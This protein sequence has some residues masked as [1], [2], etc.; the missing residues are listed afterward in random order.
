MAEKL[1]AFYTQPDVLALGVTVVIIWGITKILS[2]IHDFVHW[3]IDK[4]IETDVALVSQHIRGYLM[5]YRKRNQCE[6]IHLSDVRAL[7]CQQFMIPTHAAARIPDA[8]W[9]ALTQIVE[10]FFAIG[11]DPKAKAELCSGCL[12]GMVCETNNYEPTDFFI[13][14]EFSLNLSESNDKDPK[15]WVM[16]V[17]R[18]EDDEYPYYIQ[19]REKK[20]LMRSFFEESA[21][22]TYDYRK[23]YANYVECKNKA[24]R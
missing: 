9:R 23:V 5:D 16:W 4:D 1:W 2:P 10:C 7:L 12:S 19:V 21:D 24:F 18:S 22:M 6:E 11:A 14:L 17:D 13:W 8:H 15:R 3:V 20:D